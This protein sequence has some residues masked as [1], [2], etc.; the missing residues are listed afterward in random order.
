M[1]VAV[2]FIPAAKPLIGAEEQAAVQRVMAS[3]MLAQGPEVAAFEQEF[4]EQVVAGRHCI[5][6]NSGTS[7]LHMAFLAGGI[8]PGDEV[9]VPSFTFVST[10]N[11]FVLRG[12]IPVFIDCRADTLNLD[13]FAIAGHS[14][15]GAVAWSF[16]A[17]R[18]E[19]VSH[20]ILVDA[21]GYPREGPPPL[22]TRLARMP[23]VGDCEAAMITSVP[24]VVGAASNSLS[25][26]PSVNRL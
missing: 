8:K 19:R 15:G 26:K 2:D 23:V 4:S 24:L 3:G 13:R 5:A 14:L 18:P 22:P 20:L 1:S 9:I 6:V 17:T 7:A 25:V 21:A 10:I 12:A 16:A 11:A